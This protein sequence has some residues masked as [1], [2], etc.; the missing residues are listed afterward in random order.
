VVTRKVSAATSG[1]KAAIAL[2]TAL[3]HGQAGTGASDGGA[4]IDGPRIIVAGNEQPAQPLGPL[5]NLKNLA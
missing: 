1:E 5:V 2:V 4:D 3:H